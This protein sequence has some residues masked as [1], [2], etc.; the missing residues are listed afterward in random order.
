MNTDLP[1]ACV[2]NFSWPPNFTITCSLKQCC[3][4][5]TKVLIS[6]ERRV[7][8]LY[9]GY[10]YNLN[11]DLHNSYYSIFSY[12]SSLAFFLFFFPSLLW[13]LSNQQDI[14][15]AIVSFL[16]LKTYVMFF[17]RLMCQDYLFFYV[18]V[19]LVAEA[20]QSFICDSSH[21]KGCVCLKETEAHS[22]IYTQSQ[23]KHRSSATQ[24]Y[25]CSTS[26]LVH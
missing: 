8:G 21:I 7:R 26:T 16:W 2:S 5:S 25:L 18:I 4:I 9:I 24:T 6:P 22:A 14:V 17:K 20:K 19:Y 3:K 23:S 12:I 13:N 15:P 11:I 10:I 1:A